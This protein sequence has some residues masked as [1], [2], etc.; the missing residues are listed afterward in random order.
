MKV[1]A[2][3]PDYYE[4]GDKA[5]KI[6]AVESVRIFREVPDLEQLTVTVPRDGK[7]QTLVVTRTQ[8]EQYYKISLADLAA[9][10]SSW[11][12]TFI[13]PYDNKKSRGDFV[14]KFVTEK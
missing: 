1:P 7:D 4:S 6:L 5:N 8:I 3:T 13:Q 11:R 9:D 12:E 2:R 10:P 14:K